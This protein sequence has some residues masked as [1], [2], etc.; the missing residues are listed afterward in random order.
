M[1]SNNH[2]HALARQL[3]AWRGTTRAP[4]RL[5]FNPSFAPLACMPACACAQLLSPHIG[6]D[7][8]VLADYEVYYRSIPKPTLRLFC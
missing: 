1:Y 6:T 8:D 5:Y 3:R 2:A 4:L 7:M